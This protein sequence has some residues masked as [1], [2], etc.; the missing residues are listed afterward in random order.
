M[1]A[2]LNDEFQYY[3][4]K[5]AILVEEYGGKVIAIKECSVLGAY[6]THLEAFTETIKEHE[7]GTFIIQQVSEGNKAYTATFYSPVISTE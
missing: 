5:Q 2:T 4:D 1:T 3:L 6:D 7:R